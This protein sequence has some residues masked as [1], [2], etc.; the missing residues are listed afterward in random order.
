MAKGLLAKI[1]KGILIGGG[2]VL[3]LFAPAIGAPL[4]V[5]G[6]AINT[7]SGS[8]K[9]QDVVSVAASNLA[10]SLGTASNMQQAGNKTFSM[11]NAVA[12][13]K[14]AWSKP[15]TKIIVIILGALLLLKL[16][17]IK[18]FKRRKR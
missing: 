2:S 17:G 12:Y 10:L 8:G 15:I 11:S 1:V 5:A 7:G 4:I 13:F 3:S 9:G 6:T 18:I 14:V 16:L